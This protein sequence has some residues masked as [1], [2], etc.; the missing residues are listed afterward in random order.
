LPRRFNATKQPIGQPFRGRTR[1]SLQSVDERMIFELRVTPLRLL[2]G[3][4]LESRPCELKS[5]A[6]EKEW[7]TAQDIREKC[8]K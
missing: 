5:T 7:I 4:D 2:F 6:I 1:V 8:K 3:S